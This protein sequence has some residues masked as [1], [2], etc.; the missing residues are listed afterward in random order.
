MIAKTIL[1]GSVLLAALVV[2]AG[3]GNDSPTGSVSQAPLVRTSPE[4]GAQAVGVGDSIQMHFNEPVDTLHFHEWFYC[5]DSSAHDA[6][7]DSL[8]GGMMG[9]GNMHSDS[10]AFY[11]RM[12]DRRVMGDFHWNNDGDSCVFVPDSDLMPGTEYV[13]HFRNEMRNHEGG[14][15]RHMGEMFSVDMMFRFRT[16]GP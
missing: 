4:D 15:M 12:H 10:A 9:M 11:G 1:A 7:Q 6:L 5:I 3:C 2:L 8:M 13:M 16:M 14:R